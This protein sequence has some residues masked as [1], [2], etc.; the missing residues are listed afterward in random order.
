MQ[1]RKRKWDSYSRGEELFGLT[2]T[3]Y[4]GLEKC[5]DEIAM[6]D[7]LYSCAPSLPCASNHCLWFCPHYQAHKAHK[8]V[9]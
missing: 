1:V 5:E 2:V 3:K 4:D 8:Q 7:R 6:L 9:A